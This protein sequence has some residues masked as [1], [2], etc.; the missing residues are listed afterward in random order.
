M[1]KEEQ[2][3]IYKIIDGDE[4]PEEDIH[5]ND[6]FYGSKG[7]YSAR[8][9]AIVENKGYQFWYTEMDGI[10]EDS[11]EEYDFAFDLLRDEVKEC[12]HK[13]R[14]FNSFCNECG[15]FTFDKDHGSIVHQCTKC[16]E[17]WDDEN[18][19]WHREDI[20]NMFFNYFFW[21]TGYARM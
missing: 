15:D 16:G 5:F 2:K 3:I 14:Y 13:W 1:N 21:E 8:G 7:W 19:V 6:E 11:I 17:L 4:F 12:Y 9:Y 10:E 20:E 18:G